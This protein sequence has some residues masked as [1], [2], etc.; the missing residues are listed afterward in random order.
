MRRTNAFPPRRG[1]ATK[2]PRKH[3]PGHG[4][5]RAG[6]PRFIGGMIHQGVAEL[7]PK[8]STLPAESRRL[9]PVGQETGRSAQRQAGSAQREPGPR[10]GPRKLAM[11]VA[12]DGSPFQGW[13]IQPHGPTV[14]SK[15]EDALGVIFRQPVKVYGSGR[16]DTGVHALGQVAHFLA[17]AQQD[18]RKL[19]F[20]LNSLAA[21]SISVKALV[22]VSD[23]FHARHDATGKTYRYHIFNRPYPP[24]FGRQRCWWFRNPLNVPAMA[25]A[26]QA[27]VGKHDF[28]AFRAISCAAKSPIRDIRSLRI[29][30]GEHSGSTVRIEIEASGFLQ[31]MA[32][33][34]AGTL[35]AVGL[36]RVA[37]GAMA[38]ILAGREREAA[39]QTAPGR[40]LHL[41]RVEYDLEAYPQLGSFKDLEKG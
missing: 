19:Q 22:P 5:R 6:K 10:D 41:L 1:D 14:Q 28:S 38:G 25:E 13:Q 34:I 27:L 31:H 24:V 11:L 20:S 12:Y 9:S 35:T 29:S 16:T 39:E 2:K 33:I 40:G 37:P 4:Q 18:L 23:D 8:Q 17:P 30:E 3:L 7:R 32:R 36:G 26:A 15:L 21:P